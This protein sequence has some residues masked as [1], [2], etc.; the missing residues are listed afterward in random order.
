MTN[1]FHTKN[2]SKLKMELKALIFGIFFKEGIWGASR[3][4]RVNVK[5][6]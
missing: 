2:Y 4:I 6:L 3:P 5:N 1:E